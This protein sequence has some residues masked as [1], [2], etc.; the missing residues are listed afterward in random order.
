MAACDPVGRVCA[1]TWIVRLEPSRFL[2]VI[3]SAVFAVTVP[4]PVAGDADLRAV[5]RVVPGR[6]ALRRASPSV[7]HVRDDIRAVRR[8]GTSVEPLT[9]M[10]QTEPSRV[11]TLK[12]LDVTSLT[13]PRTLG[14]TT[15]MRSTV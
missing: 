1:S 8:T 11:V 13:V 12:P 3:E 15:A 7:L 4:R 5:L 9:A 14:T 6:G 10:V 2:I